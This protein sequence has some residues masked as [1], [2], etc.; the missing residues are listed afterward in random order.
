[1]LFNHH[2]LFASFLS[3][4]NLSILNLIFRITFHR[5]ISYDTNTITMSKEVSPDQL[6]Q[7]HIAREEKNYNEALSLHKPVAELKNIQDRIDYL[8]NLF[9]QVRN[10]YKTSS[11][12]N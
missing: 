12:G 6:I 5:Y 11:S 3:A 10:R 7:L 9:N 8:K 4:A 2:F 1:M